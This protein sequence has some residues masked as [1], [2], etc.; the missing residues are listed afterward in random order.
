MNYLSKIM[1]N[2]EQIWMQ[3]IL[4]MVTAL[5]LSF[6]YFFVIGVDASINRHNYGV[7]RTLTLNNLVLNEVSTEQL[8]KDVEKIPSV[9]NVVFNTLEEQNIIIIKMKD[10]RQRAETIAQLPEYII[11]AGI[12]FHQI[13]TQF[14]LIT[15][16]KFAGILA[17]VFMGIVVMFF[18]FG[19]MHH[20]RKSC[21]ITNSLLNIL[22]YS[23]KS[24]FKMTL[25]P[26]FESSLIAIFLFIILL[27]F[28]V[29]PVLNGCIAQISRL[30]NLGV[31]FN[32]SSLEYIVIMF[33]VIILYG[34]MFLKSTTENNS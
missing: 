24:R 12:V 16:F 25:F 23:R 26:F 34:I 5:V 4:I 10:Y 20:I 3:A 31:A 13:E 14:D 8:S 28:T 1:L 17:V 30:S 27:K 33:V 22:G 32:L 19:I 18:Y 29:I 21:E 2:R 11:S 9:D 15:K 6:G 7:E